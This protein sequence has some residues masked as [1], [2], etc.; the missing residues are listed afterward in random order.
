MPLSLVDVLAPLGDAI[1]ALADE[2]SRRSRRIRIEEVAQRY[3]DL[4]AVVQ[5]MREVAQ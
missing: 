5:E 4:V 3:A 1:M 2:D